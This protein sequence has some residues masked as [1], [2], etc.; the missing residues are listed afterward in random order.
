VLADHLDRLGVS[1]HAVVLALP[2][3]GVPIGFEVA[4]ALRLPLD[5]FVVPGPARTDGRRLAFTGIERAEL[6]RREREYRG[7]R[8]R[9]SVAGRIVILVDDGLATSAPMHAAVKAVRELKPLRVVVAAPV[10]APEAC[11]QLMGIADE[12]VCP[13]TPPRF[14]SVGAWYDDF[15]LPTDAEIRRLLD[16]VDTPLS[17]S[18]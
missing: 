8:P 14:G 2:R 15:S 12:V 3:G 9:V 18:A 7:I 17:W 10:G 11:W 1:H 4:N 13:L 16:H 5:V 6:V